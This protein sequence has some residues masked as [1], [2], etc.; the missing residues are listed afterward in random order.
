MI[1]RMIMNMIINPDS[2]HVLFTKLH[3][4]SIRS[5]Q[6]RLFKAQQIRPA[7]CYLRRCSSTITDTFGRWTWL[8]KMARGFGCYSRKV[9]PW[10]NTRCVWREGRHV[11]FGIHFCGIW[12][13]EMG[14]HWEITAYNDINPGKLTAGTP[15][16][17][18]GSD[19]FPD[20]NWVILFASICEF[21]GVYIICV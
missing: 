14:N 12:R 19:D 13:L 9:V 18:F 21:S 16:W 15:K 5:F 1:T 20:F 4:Q 6:S 3:K 11:V 2:V 17:R 10:S 8:W 7:R